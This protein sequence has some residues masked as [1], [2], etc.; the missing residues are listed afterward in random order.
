MLLIKALLVFCAGLVLAR[1]VCHAGALSELGFLF[2][3]GTQK[4][5]AD[6]EVG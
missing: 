3:K 5:E 6:E 1:F 4:E 2:G